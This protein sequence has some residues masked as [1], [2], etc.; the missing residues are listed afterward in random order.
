MIDIFKIIIHYYLGNLL[1]EKKIYFQ[2]YFLNVFLNFWG[3]FYMQCILNS[4]KVDIKIT[5]IFSLYS[6]KLNF[7]LL[8]TNF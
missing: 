4:L 1:K 6:L 3:N 2:I 8:I 5:F 7:L